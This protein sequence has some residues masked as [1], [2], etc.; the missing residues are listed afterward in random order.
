M[1]AGA[2]RTVSLSIEE[3]EELGKE[4]LEWVLIEKG[5]DEK[6]PRSRFAQFYSIKKMIPRKSW[7]AFIQLP[8]FLPY[9]E[10]AQ[11]ILA[12]RCMDQDVMEKSFG[13]RF[14]RLYERDVVEDENDL[15]IL[16]AQAGKNQEGDDDEFIKWAKYTQANQKVSISGKPPESKVENEQSILYQG[17]T[18]E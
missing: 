16:K 17:Q 5:E 9:Y 13:H 11:A 6:Y 1:P 10:A 18:G 12:Q 14:L 3:M 7:K 8:E 4:L 2:P 15:V